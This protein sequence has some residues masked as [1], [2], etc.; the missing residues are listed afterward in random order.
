MTCL[1]DP[2]E[3]TSHSS[4]LLLFQFG[5][6]DSLLLESSFRDSAAF[7]RRHS[8]STL[9]S[10]LPPLSHGPSGPLDYWEQRPH[11]T[12]PP[13]RCRS[14]TP[15]DPSSSLPA[16]HRFSPT[17]DFPGLV[18]SVHRHHHR[19]LAHHHH[20]HG[21]NSSSSLGINMA[22]TATNNGNMSSKTKG[23]TCKVCGDEASGFHYGVDSCEGCK[24]WKLAPLPPFIM[25]SLS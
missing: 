8:S 23:P 24:V 5:A 7:N 19:P 21:N 1:V 4:P 12:S 16:L 9:P 20:H 10:C 11:S 22:A 14:C 15:P 2:F 17:S 13:H 18:P 3:G 6:E 25:T